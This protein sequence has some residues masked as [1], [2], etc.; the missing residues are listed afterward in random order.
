MPSKRIPPKPTRAALAAVVRRNDLIGRERHAAAVGEPHEGPRWPVLDDSQAGPRGGSLDGSTDGRILLDAAPPDELH[1]A[2][3]VRARS[4]GFS[5]TGRL[6]LVRGVGR[7]AP[8]G[9]GRR[10][11]LRPS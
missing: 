10:R 9:A 1:D 11:S 4:S 8:S 6:R 3:S 2:E 7:E 5:V